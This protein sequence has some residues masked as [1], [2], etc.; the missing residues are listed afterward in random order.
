[1]RVR[2]DCSTSNREV[3][4][5]AQGVDTPVRIGRNFAIAKQVVF[6]SRFEHLIN[7]SC[8]FA[9]ASLCAVGVYFGI[10]ALTDK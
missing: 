1:M 10:A 2:G 5:R 6:C 7:S 3:L 8:L 4:H 9:Q